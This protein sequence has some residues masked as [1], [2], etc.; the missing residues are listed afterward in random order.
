MSAL[1]SLASMLSIPD[2]INTLPPLP[3]PLGL[4]TSSLAPPL[5]PTEPKLVTVKAEAFL[6]STGTSPVSAALVT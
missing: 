5:M 6:G 3:R 2:R 4:L 1:I